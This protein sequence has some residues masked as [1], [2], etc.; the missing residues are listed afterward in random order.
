MISPRTVITSFQLN[1]SRGI[2]TTEPS[3]ISTPPINPPINM[4]PTKY[5]LQI[6]FFQSY[7]N[8][9]NDAGTHAAQMCR[10]VDEIPSLLFP[11]SNNNGT[12]TPMTGPAT[13]HGQGL[14]INSIEIEI[15]FKASNVFYLPTMKKLCVLLLVVL[16]VECSMGQEIGRAHV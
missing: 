10:S 7:W 4:P 14:Y 8:N 6:S 9:G 12:V 2:S 11:I 5:K 16:S 15:L 13:Y 1:I 3:F